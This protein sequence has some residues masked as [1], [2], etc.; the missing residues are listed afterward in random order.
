[1]K[2]SEQVICLELNMLPT[3]TFQKEGSSITFLTYW[4]ACLFYLFKEKI[5]K[6]SVCNFKFNLNTSEEFPFEGHNCDFW[7]DS[8]AAPELYMK[9]MFRSNNTAMY[10]SIVYPFQ[11]PRD[12]VNG[13]MVKKCPQLLF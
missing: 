5:E 12:V 11:I 10:L 7:C 8:F 9:E 6:T 3:T 13:L 4:N 1:M 2:Q